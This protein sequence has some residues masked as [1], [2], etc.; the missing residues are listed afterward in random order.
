MTVS[1]VGG[2]RTVCNNGRL[3]VGVVGNYGKSQGLARQRADDE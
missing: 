2:V 1:A 3:M